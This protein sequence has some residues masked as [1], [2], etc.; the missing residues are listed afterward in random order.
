MAEETNHATMTVPVETGVLDKISTDA[1]AIHREMVVI[2]W[3]AFLIAA[4]LLHRLAW[5]PMLRA[6][7]KREREIRSALDE[8]DKAHKQAAVDA[9][10]NRQAISEVAERARAMQEESRLASER[11]ATRIDQESREKARRLIEDAGRE[12]ES[13][14]LRAMDDLRREAAELAIHLS[15]K[16]LSE[17][18]TP[19]QR[20]DY[21]ARM[22]K[23]LPS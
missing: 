10:K 1:I 22:L 7:D 14:R 6:L 9:E 20:R 8:A 21:Q 15:E 19:E 4:V 11:A 23:D 13:A 3:V 2:T 16:M 5:K 12:I 18:M 17:K